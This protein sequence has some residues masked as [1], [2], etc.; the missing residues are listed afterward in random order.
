MSWFVWFE[1]ESEGVPWARSSSNFREQNWEGK[2][3]YQRSNN[4]NGNQVDCREHNKSYQCLESY[5]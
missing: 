3:V 1:A 4:L 5:H 2:R